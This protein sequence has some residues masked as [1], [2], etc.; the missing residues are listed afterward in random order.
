MYSRDIVVDKD[1]LPTINEL[2]A[3][4]I[5]LGTF[6][7][8][9]GV[10]GAEEN[11]KRASF[12]AGKREFTSGTGVRKTFCFNCDSEEHNT[13]DCVKPRLDCV[14]CGILA[15][16]MMKHCLVSNGKVLPV[17]LPEHRKKIIL[18][19]RQALIERKSTPA[20]AAVLCAAVDDQHVAV[21]EDFWASLGSG[22]R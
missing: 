5:N 15:G 22:Y 1:E 3:K 14:H 21:D 6:K 12:L 2:K 13:N 17:T 20:N 9:A 11:T 8:T 10:F 16:H 18:A 7:G 4:L 19:K